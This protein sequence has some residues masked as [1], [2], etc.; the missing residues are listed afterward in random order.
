[1]R[2][3]A[4]IKRTLQLIESIW[5][6]NPDWRLGQLLVNAHPE[7]ER[8]NRAFFIEDTE[9]EWA[10]IRLREEVGCQQ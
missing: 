1:M 2:D 4:R 6:A 9:I 7:F 10:L 5:A 8:D 3:P